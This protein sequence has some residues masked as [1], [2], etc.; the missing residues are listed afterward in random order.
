[1]Y[2]L[3]SQEHAV[4]LFKK[5]NQVEDRH[6]F[7]VVNTQKEAQALTHDLKTLLQGID[8]VSSVHKAVI[9]VKGNKQ[10]LSKVIKV[11]PEQPKLLAGLKESQVIYMRNFI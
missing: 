10:H 1:M 3:E 2:Y 8:I 4:A 5:L 6:I 7:I 11:I 9:K